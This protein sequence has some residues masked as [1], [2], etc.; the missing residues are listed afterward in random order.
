MSDSKSAAARRPEE[1]PMQT[2]KSTGRKTIAA[3][4]AALALLTLWA[5]GEAAANSRL[6][7]RNDTT[8]LLR[9][10]VFSGS[11]A[12]CSSTE[13]QGSIKSGESRG[14]GCS[15]QGKD[16]CKLQVQRRDKGPAVCENLNMNSCGMGHALIVPD[17]SLIVV[18]QDKTCT[19]ST[20]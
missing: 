11:D 1:E 13:K 2:R 10:Y 12:I 8:A 4:A 18:A 3:L 15:G 7:I 5:P 14:I 19:M 16:R 6:T 20:P 9:F 17:G